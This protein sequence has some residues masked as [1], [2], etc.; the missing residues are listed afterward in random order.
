MVMKMKRSINDEIQH[1]RYDERDGVVIEKREK[2]LSMLWEKI[3]NAHDW[4]LAGVLRPAIMWMLMSGLAAWIIYQV[5]DTVKDAVIAMLLV[6]IIS[7]IVGVGIMAL[8][9]F[10]RGWEEETDGESEE[11]RQHGCLGSNIRDEVGDENS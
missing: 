7:L 1:W 6:S 11:P 2:V 5:T 9:L 4:M 3:R 10:W 8:E